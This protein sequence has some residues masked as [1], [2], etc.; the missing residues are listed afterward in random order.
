MDPTIA[1]ALE[2]GIRAAR[3]GH[4]EPAQKLL[5]TVVKAEPENEEAWLWL[6][7]V[8]D[9][10][11]RRAECLRRVIQ[12]NPDNRWAA[13]ELVALRGDD[14]GNGAAAPG[15]AEP[16][17]QPPTTPEVGLT[18][19]LCP[20]CGATPEL[21]GGGGIKTLVCTSCGSVIDLTR[22]EAAVVGQVD[23]TFKPAVAIEPGMEGEFDGEMHQVLGWIC[24]MGEDDGERW[25]WD[26]WLLLSSSGKYRWLSYDRE[27][28]F[29]LQEKILPTAPFDPYYV[30]HLPV[31]GGFAK[32]TE[33]APATIIALSGELTWRAEVDDKIYYVEARLGDKCYSVE[34]TK[35]EIE[36]L[37]GRFLKAGEM[38]RAFSIKEVAALAGQA[39]D[40]ERAKGLYRMAAYVCVICVLLSG[41]GALVSYLTGQ[42]VVKQEF[43]VVPRSV[44]TYPLE[45][46]NPGVV[47]EISIDTNLTVGNWAVV[48]MTLIDD[49]DQEYGLFE[50]EFWDEEGRD[51]DG[52]W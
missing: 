14:S 22:E 43:L 35:D 4:K 33:K 39:E 2:K 11:T 37:E 34:R 10:P 21:R 15:H 49:E 31:P 6:S 29:A 36:L 51:S 16:T 28:G 17:W 7:R 23:Q 20:Q 5:V 41:T 47:H 26:E 46:K 50:A 1:D 13:D 45:I 3:R 18:Q 19:L 27:E 32:V 44:I 12:L 40:K 8:V 24:F 9:D 30:S 52:Y 48:E 25:T 38:K 42:Q